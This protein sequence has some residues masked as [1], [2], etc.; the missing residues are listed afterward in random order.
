MSS[1]L[2]LS[3]VAFA[4]T[5]LILTIV[6]V[7][8]FR[9]GI[10]P[11]AYW[12][13]GWSALLESA[14][15]TLLT[16]E[17]PEIEALGPLF[18]TFVAPF[19]VL[20]AC[21]HTGREEPSWIIPVAFLLGA[22]RSASWL[23]GAPENA[24]SIAMATDPMLAAVAS[25]VI[26]HP[27]RDPAVPVALSDRIL[28]F[29]F[30]AYGAVEFFDASSRAGGGFGWANWIAWI[31]VGVPLG[32][33]QIA[34]HLDRFGRKARRDED[35]ARANEFRLRALTDSSTDFLAEFDDRGVLTFASQ[36]AI[37]AS[38]SA[39]PG[40]LGRN[41]SE[42]LLADNAS[43]VAIALRE[44]GQITAED[45]AAEP[46]SLQ[47]AVFPDG[48]ERWFEF[49]ATGYTTPARELR[50]LARIRDVTERASQEE[51]LRKSEAR[52]R[53]A[54]QIA[55]L[56][57]WE[58]DL[59]TGQLTCSETLFQMH[60]A[61][62]ASGLDSVTRLRRRIHPEDR[63]RTIAKIAGLPELAKPVEHT[64]RI[65]RELDGEIRTLRT[66]AEVDVDGAGEST[67]VVG[68]TIDI[69]DHLEL[70][71]RLRQGQERF[72]SLIDS[73]IVSVFV[74]DRDGWIREANDTFL[75]LLGYSRE[76]LP[77]DW[78]ALTAPEYREEDERRAAVTD[79]RD[80][81]Q[82]Y[83]KE[84]LAR[85]GRRV[86]VLI[87]DAQISQDSALLI[88]IDVT[89]RRQI[90]H[91]RAR[92]ERELEETVAVRTRELLESRARLHES[93]RLAVVGTLAAGVAHQINNPIGAI[94]NCS[95]YAL[96]C[97]DDEDARDIFE[98]ALIDNLAEVQRC[99]Q[100]VRSMLQ[101]SRDQ[102][103][104]KWVED[105]NRVARRAQRAISAYAKDRRA[106]IAFTTEDEGLLA[107]ISPIELEQAIVNVLRNAIESRPSGAHVSLRLA[108]RDK[109]ATIEITD[110]GRGI[111]P[112][113]QERLFEPFFSTRTREGGT[114]LGLSVAHGIVADHGGQIRIESIL[115]TGTRVVIHLP[116]DPSPQALVF[117]VQRGN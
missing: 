107:R 92:Y 96:L 91:D 41:I 25:W 52:L 81:T 5:A 80:L 45:V 53:R 43:R 1:F 40:L 47:R 17:Y 90:E 57:S 29:G 86:P 4:S 22:F 98:R 75:S 65:V 23:L 10:Q 15:V 54:E 110:D 79:Q 28:S 51:R 117:A 14:V 48:S 39:S 44:K 58:L 46:G 59:R 88:G 105:L 35:S 77:L 21:A 108:R 7:L 27:R 99:A 66:I 115:E 2:V 33:T 112:E 9:L 78:R 113:H 100:I 84:F 34:V 68:A 72:Q 76:N 97:R 82:P 69:T 89:A 103:T 60:G 16:T 31:A 8:L 114:G 102:P 64:Y 101:F 13:I 11:L 74:A 67:R 111:P 95:E 49:A 26:V 116:I 19:M 42:F 73:S 94:L 63:K 85:D 106:T 50:I 104:T 83:E 37:A 38:G 61:T 24:I 36:G 62:T 12:L 30:L 109:W 56:G 20:G 71:N 32:T 6:S 3:L 55:G 93:E 18:S 87:S 70:M